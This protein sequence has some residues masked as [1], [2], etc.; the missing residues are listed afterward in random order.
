MCLSPRACDVIGV[1][2]DFI[3][4][5]SAKTHIKYVGPSLIL[6]ATCKMF[7]QPIRIL[8]GTYVLVGLA[9]LRLKTLARAKNLPKEPNGWTWSR[10]LHV[11]C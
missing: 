4:L 9:F 11:N 5:V 6:K 10:A 2:N 1:V 7:A 3:E 8:M